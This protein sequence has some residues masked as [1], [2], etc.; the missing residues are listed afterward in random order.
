MLKKVQLERQNEKR[1]LTM[2]RKSKEEKYQ[3]NAYQHQKIK[4]VMTR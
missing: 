2:S 3:E 4:R 1:D